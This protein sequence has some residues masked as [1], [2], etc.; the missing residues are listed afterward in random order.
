MIIGPV[1]ELLFRVYYQETITS[2]FKTHQW[3]GVIIASAIFG[4]WHL[5]NGSFIQVLLTFGIGCVFGFAKHYIKELHYP[6]VALSH[7]LYDFLNYIV[8]LT[9][10]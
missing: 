10:V 3:V 9:I 6:G 4:L 5:I 7:G 1:E 8:R 2:L